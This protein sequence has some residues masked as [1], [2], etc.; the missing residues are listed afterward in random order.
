M[1]MSLFLGVLLIEPPADAYQQSQA[2]LEA[3]TA[4]LVELPPQEVIAKL[5][6]A[7]AQAQAHPRELIGDPS[8]A[9]RLARA[10]LALA[11]AQLATGDEAAASAT[12]DQ[13]IFGAGTSSLPL[14]GLG[15]EIRKLHDE[16]RA[17]LETGGHGTI[18]VDCDGCEVSVDLRSF[19]SSAPLLLGTHRVWLFDPHGELEQRLVEVVLSTADEVVQLEYRAT[20]EPEVQPGGRSPLQPRASSPLQPVA[21][22]SLEPAPADVHDH[23]PRWPKIVGMSVGAGLLVAGGVLLALDGKCRGGGVPTADN[24]DTCGEVFQGAIPSYAL[25]GVGGGLLLGASVWLTVDET[26]AKQRQVSAGVG[27]SLRF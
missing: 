16:R 1:S 14:S 25:L 9:N 21:P 5:T 6:A 8:S 4:E 11:W 13:A 7:L 18:S 15:P 19:N 23:K 20:P 26:R 10:R 12:M 3:A 27:W 22:S 2:A 17:A 24:V